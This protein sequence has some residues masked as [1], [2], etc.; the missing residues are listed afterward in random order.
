MNFN[1]I[2]KI[3][4]ENSNS[5]IAIFLRHA[6]KSQDGDSYLTQ[7]GVDDT[8]NLAYKLQGLNTNIRIF[9]SPEPRCEQTAK[10]IHS[11]LQIPS[12][13]LYFSNALGKPG[14]Q[15]LDNDLYEKLYH[16]FKCR[17]IFHQWKN[18]KHYNALRNPKLLKYVANIFFQTTCTE[19]GITLYISQSGTVAS[20][21]YA[22]ELL[23]YDVTDDEWVDFLEGFMISIPEIN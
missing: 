9:T 22:L 17:D 14:L 7:K 20:I 6:D 16:E 8:V 5:K 15:I 12:D 10:I 19:K 2:K 23:N 13:Q 11:R 3:L 18:G 21:G 4:D 1:K